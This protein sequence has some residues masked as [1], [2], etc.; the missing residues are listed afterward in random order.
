M[1]EQLVTILQRRFGLS[2]L[3]AE[4]VLADVRH[5]HEVAL[6][7]AMRDRI[8]VDDAENAVRLCLEGNE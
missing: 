2:R 8:H 1:F 3:D 6:Y 4:L 7:R 5:A